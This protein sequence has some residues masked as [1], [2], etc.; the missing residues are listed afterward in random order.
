MNPFELRGPE[1]LAF[2]AA[3]GLVVLGLLF[4]MRHAGEPEDGSRISLSDPYS[5]ACLRGGRNEALRVATVSLIDRGLLQVDGSRLQTRNAEDVERVKDPLETA[6]LEKFKWPGD[7]AAAMFK[8]DDAGLVA[9]EVGRSLERLGL[10]AGERTTWDRRS[11]LILAVVALWAVAAIKIAIGLSHDR[12]VGFLFLL[13]GVLSG[14]AVRLHDPRRTRRGDTLLE[15]LRT[16]FRQLKER[17]HQLRPA[18]DAAEATL[19]AAVFG[20]AMLPDAEWVHV[21][22]LYPKA[23]GSVG[24]TWSSSFGTSCGS[25][26]GSSCGGGGCGGGCGGCGGG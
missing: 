6:I 9:D 25:A 24:S 5:I 19:L 14:L 7:E 1:F 21:R 18:T 26:C 17:A 12:P 23:N 16:L 11:R 2:Y 20:L 4:L 13:A 8:D 10:F 3:Y 22:K 15:D